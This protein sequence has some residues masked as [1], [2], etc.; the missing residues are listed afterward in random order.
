MHGHDAVEEDV[1][2]QSVGAQG[3]EHRDGGDGGLQS[4]S[5]LSD[6]GASVI[7]PEETV[8]MS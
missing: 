5:P 6:A 1:D 4:Y 2:V 8:R 7:E 3:V